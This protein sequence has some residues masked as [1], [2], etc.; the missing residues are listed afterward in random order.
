MATRTGIGF[1]GG[2]G[3]GAGILYFLDQGTSADRVL[4][5][6]VRAALGRAASHPCAVEVDVDGSCVTLSGP[7][8]ASEAEEILERAGRTAGVE[9][10]VDNL[11]RHANADGLPAMAA[12]AT[13]RPRAGMEREVWPRSLRMV[14]GGAGLGLGMAG[15]LRGGLTGKLVAAAGG[16]L[17]A[18]AALNRQLPLGI[19]LRGGRMTELR[20]ALVVQAPVHEVFEFWTD[21]TNYP[22]FM[23]HV[24]EV[25]ANERDPDRTHWVVRGPAGVP[26]SWDAEVTRCVQDSIFAWKSLPGSA[27]EHS[28]TILFEAIG[29]DTTRVRVHMI[30]NPPAG[31][32]GH[33]VASLLGGDPKSRMDDDLARFKALIEEKVGARREEHLQET[34]ET[35]LRE[36]VL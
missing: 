35:V 34:I 8:L 20:K 22:R 19:G 30:Y 21:V 10:L 3:L 2:A 31:A 4:A 12:R 7:V 13:R 1:L 36:R 6:R 25:R 33:A 17:F 9:E 24:V 18:R 26:V 27:I 28:G 5:A 16:A 14:A 15:L 29:A 11:E 32:F 23:H